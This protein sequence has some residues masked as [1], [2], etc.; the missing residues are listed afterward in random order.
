MSKN[1][2]I[3]LT[4]F[5]LFNFDKVNI[6]NFV[7]NSNPNFTSIIEEIIN[8]KWYPNVCL[9]TNP[10]LA[11]LLIDNEDKLDFNAI[12]SNSNPGLTGF[13]I[14]HEDKITN[15]HRLMMNNN[16]VNIK[17]IFPFSSINL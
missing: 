1:N 12:A 17:V 10:L 15:K 14:I 6:S 16:I 11:R 7:S 4:D 2:N 8:H 13:I 3:L 9:N 5:I